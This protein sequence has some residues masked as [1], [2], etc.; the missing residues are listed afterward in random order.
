[1]ASQGKESN[2]ERLCVALLVRAREMAR[3]TKR[4]SETNS[5]PLS[6]EESILQEADDRTSIV[7][8]YYAVFLY[9]REKAKGMGYVER[10]E[11][12][13]VHQQLIKW[14]WNSQNQKL[15]RE[16]KIRIGDLLYEIK[17]RRR[18]A[19]YEISAMSYTKYLS[20]DIIP[21][22]EEIINLLSPKGWL[23]SEMKRL[24]QQ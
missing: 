14:Y 1:M 17:K 5:Y 7:T 13:S 8:A 16:E 22:A 15:S 11:K 10:M 9:A 23:E 4:Y 12:G 21:K 24:E 18:K 20:G 19:S 6:E 3:G 2:C